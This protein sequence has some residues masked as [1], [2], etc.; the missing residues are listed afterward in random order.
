MPQVLLPKAFCCSGLRWRAVRTDATPLSMPQVLLPNM[1]CATGMG[2]WCNAL[3]QTVTAWHL[4]RRWTPTF[5]A[6]SATMSGA[7]GVIKTGM[8]AS[9]EL[10]TSP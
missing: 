4:Y 5:N 1:S 2:H 6:P 8:K 9:G 7:A 10:I 3:S